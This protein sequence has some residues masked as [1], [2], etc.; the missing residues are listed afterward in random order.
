MAVIEEGILSLLTINVNKMGYDTTEAYLKFI[1]SAFINL[2]KIKTISFSD[3]DEGKEPARKVF[4][5]MYRE[6]LVFLR[7]L[8]AKK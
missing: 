3:S 4:S 7:K 2:S 8:H 1:G 5:S 6:A